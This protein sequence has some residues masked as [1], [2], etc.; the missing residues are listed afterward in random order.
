MQQMKNK[1]KIGN[2]IQKTNHR[3][4]GYA[5]IHLHI[6]MGRHRHDEVGLIYNYLKLWY[7]NYLLNSFAVAMVIILAAL[8]KAVSSISKR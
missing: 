7:S 8:S 5:G 1:I 2:Y 4:T 6:N 3:H